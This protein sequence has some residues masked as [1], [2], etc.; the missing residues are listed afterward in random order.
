MTSTSSRIV[1]VLAIAV[2]AGP[3]LGQAEAPAP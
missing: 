2:L 1:P 3:A